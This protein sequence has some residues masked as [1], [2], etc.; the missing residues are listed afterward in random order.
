MDLPASREQ[1]AGK[2]KVKSQKLENI[3]PST[4][5]HFEQGLV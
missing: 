1:G 2:S 3:T 4:L 5:Q